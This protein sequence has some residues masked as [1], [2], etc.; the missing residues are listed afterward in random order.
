[1]NISVKGEDCVR[2]IEQQCILMLLKDFKWSQ[3]MATAL[4]AIINNWRVVAFL[5]LGAQA[6]S[7]STFLRARSY[8]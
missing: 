4:K 6:I 3:Q 8:I 5:I 1:M 7:D 2:K